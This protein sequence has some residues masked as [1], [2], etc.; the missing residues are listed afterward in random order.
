MSDMR[1]EEDYARLAY[2][3]KIYRKQLTILQREI[4]RITLTSMDMTNGMMTVGALEKREAFI[5][6]G[7]G[8]FV[9]GHITDDRIILSIGGGYLVEMDKKTANEKIKSRIEAT[10]V[11]VNRLSQEFGGISSKL[12]EASTQIRELEKRIIIDKQVEEGAN[13]DYA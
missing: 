2:E 4:E 3:M 10:K 13:E 7:G 11:A 9:K 12:E 5:P 8:T 1:L 6:I